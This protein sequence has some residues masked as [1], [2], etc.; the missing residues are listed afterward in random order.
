MSS[1]HNGF[2]MG[3]HSQWMLRIALG[4]VLLHGLVGSASSSQAQSAP[5]DRESGSDYTWFSDGPSCVQSKSIFDGPRS[6]A[7]GLESQTRQV[8][9]MSAADEQE[10][11]ARIMT[12][13]RREKGE[14]I[15][16]S[17]A[18]VDYTRGVA[19]NLTP[20][21]ERTDMSYAFYVLDVAEPNAFALPG[22]HIFVTRGM[23]QA[24][25]QNEAQLAGILGHEIAHVDKRHCAALFQYLRKL[26]GPGGDDLAPVVGMFL[27]MPYGLAH[28]SEAD[29]KGVSISVKAG[30][31]PFQMVVLMD[32]L[33]SRPSVTTK[34][35]PLHDPFSL[36]GYVVQGGMEE[37]ENAAATHPRPK[38]R[39]CAL[40]QAVYRK[41][42]R[43]SGRD[44]FVGT[45]RYRE[46]VGIN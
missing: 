10:L 23:L 15:V 35:P 8:E 16:E 36:F 9:P 12:A 18:L 37:L 19:A 26:I 43:L 44:F 3:Q 1:L 14:Q 11:G 38:D 29:A 41:R 5:A 27:R 20:H 24:Q 32:S 39:A 33:P 21:V 31:S 28:E 4:A 13:F 42:E 30:Y 17:G 6:I 34:P 7:G 22:G 25:L 2:M 45:Q 40:K 46:H